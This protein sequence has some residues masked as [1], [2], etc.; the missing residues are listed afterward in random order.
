MKKMGIGVAGCGSTGIQSVCQH[1][2]FPD[3]CELVYT[4]AVMDP[5]PGRAKDVYKRQALYMALSLP[6]FPCGSIQTKRLGACLYNSHMVQI[7][8]NL[9]PKTQKAR[10]ASIQTWVNKALLCCV[11]QIQIPRWL[12]KPS[13]SRQGR[14]QICFEGR[15]HLPKHDCLSEIRRP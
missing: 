3:E 7:L 10:T 13:A 8:C 5:V 4:A 2:V 9:Q 6:L 1:T 11:L 14:P 12:L 15:P